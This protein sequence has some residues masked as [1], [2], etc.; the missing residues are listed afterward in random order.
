MQT[1]KVDSLRVSVGVEGKPVIENL[2]FS[3]SRGEALLVL[4]PTGSGKTTLLL[5]LSGVIPGLLPGD[6]K[7][8]VDIA[9]HDPVSEGLKGL[10]GDVGIVFQDPEAQVVMDTVQD[11]VAFPLENLFYNPTAINDQVTKCLAKTGLL[12]YASEKTDTL[13]TGLKQRLAIA[14]TL[15]FNPKVLLL[16]EPTA[17]IDP[18]S[19]RKIYELLRT[20]KEEGGTLVIVEHR[21]EYL[22]DIVDKILFLYKG[23]GILTRDFNDLVNNFGFSALV[24]AGVWLPYKILKELSVNKQSQ[25]LSGPPEYTLGSPIIKVENLNV[26]LNGKAI[27]RNV[28]FDVNRGELLVIIGPN[29]SGKTT[30]L[31]V[32]AGLIRKYSGRISVLGGA[33][34][35]KKIAY[36]SQI[37]EH[38][39]TERT[40]SEEVAST[41]LQTGITKERALKIAMG[42]LEARGL[43][44]LSSAGVYE[45]S[46][47]EKR[48]VSLLEMELLNRPI[49][50]L[51]EPT[52]GLDLRHTLNV[53][54]RINDV[55]LKGKT[56][57]LVTHDTWILPLFNSRVI[58]LSSGKI[59]FQGSFKEL[60]TKRELWKDLSFS[61]PPV[62]QETDRIED[63]DEAI[64]N[65]RNLVFSIHDA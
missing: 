57:I 12:D 51:D 25:P 43:G 42:E 8:R 62:F 26:E 49:I 3:L 20:F 64:K 28:S 63:Q 7:G 18:A 40:V 4:G 58:G 17:H 50:L 33:P 34:S 39:F 21:L 32:L 41:L 61:P 52:F 60:L 35:H 2:T 29:G 27:L 11:E 59:M 31:K 45:I 23:K 16:D 65:I 13:S 37:P 14:S 38:Q 9:G 47:G 46:Q 48:L 44:H 15:C 22:G 53:V 19:S 55:I 1:V 54:K 30:L 56:V 5:S 6:V 36:V 10:A 24:R